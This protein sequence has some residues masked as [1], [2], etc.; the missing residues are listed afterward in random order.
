MAGCWTAS[1]RSC[2]PPRRSRCMSS[3]SPASARPRGVALLGSTGSI[4]V[5]AVDVLEAHADRFRVVA[6]AAGG[7]AT[8]LE[9]QAARLRPAVV[10]L[11]D[12]TTPV[13]LPPGTARVSGEDALVELATR[14]DVD[15]VVVGT[16]GVV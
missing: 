15:L 14:D 2:S 3:S 4:G 5:Q 9:S 6:L 10:A 1:T 16:G 13:D 7:N 8:E 12:S 11:R